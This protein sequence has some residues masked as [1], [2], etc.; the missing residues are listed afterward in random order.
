MVNNQHLN[1][2]G[3]A[4]AANGNLYVA[5]QSNNAVDVFEPNGTFV[6]QFA[7]GDI[8]GPNAIALDDSGHLYVAQN[9][10]GL[11][12]FE[13][14]GACV[15][16]C[17]SLDP[18]ANLGVTTDP[19]GHVYADEG[20]AITEL[21]SAGEQ[22]DRFGVGTLATGRGLAFDDASGDIY[23][24]DE[25]AGKVEVFEPLTV[26]TVTV[27]STTN[28]GQTSITLTGRVDP[29]SAHGGGEITECSFE[30]G[31]TETYGNTAPC[32]AISNLPYASATEVHANL[33]G[34]TS[35][36][37]YHYRLV[38][39]DADGDGQGADHTFI[40]HAVVGLE[41][42]PATGV[43]PTEAVLTGSFIGNGEDTH[44][45]FNWGTTESYGETTRNLR[46]RMQASHLDQTVLRFR[47]HST[48]CCQLRPIISRW[49]PAT[50]VARA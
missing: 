2:T 38:A 12:E 33:S 5:D 20:S 24:A 19:E 6:S 9:G 22:I 49:L 31:K 29:D 14:S 27:G 37:V 21:N 42:G 34:L 16:S 46:A 48:I 10:S 35:D 18:S 15:N 8:S 36:V 43:T 39:G 50:P 41:T 1:P 23:V 25:G 40:T 28:P 26:P 3:L 11:V 32:K 30:Y 45:Y 13:P 4:V 7:A 44:Y 17:T 47:R